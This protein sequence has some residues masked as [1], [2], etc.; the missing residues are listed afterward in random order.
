[1]SK[2]LTCIVHGKVQGVS[3]RDYTRECARKL[4]LVGTVRNCPDETVEVIAEGEESAL[5]AF[6]LA[7]KTKYPYVKITGIDEVWSDAVGSY[8]DFRIL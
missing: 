1:M 7:L 3:F 8:T 5:K 2:C 4:A 6:I